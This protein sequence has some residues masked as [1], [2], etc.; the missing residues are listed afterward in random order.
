MV[1]YDRSDST[2]ATVTFE[3]EGGLNWTAHPDEDGGRASQALRTAEGVWLVDPLHT[4]DLDDIVDPLGEVVGVAVLSSWHARDA[5]EVARRHDV[6]VHIPEWMGRIDERV[7][8]PIERYGLAPGDAGFRTIP[9]R[10][11]PG[12]EEVFLYHEPGGTLVVPDS[13][14]TTDLHLIADERLGLAWFRRLQPPR[15]LLGLDPDRILV[16]HGDP[17]TERPAEALS[18]ALDGARRTTPTALRDGGSDI[19]RSLL[20]AL[21]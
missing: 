16:G 11:F 17:V 18:D 4:P 13:L 7:D 9:C 2:G 14:G 20:G 6:S 15:Q 21:G 10:P 1:M 5:G 8:A 3:W 12:W 19:F